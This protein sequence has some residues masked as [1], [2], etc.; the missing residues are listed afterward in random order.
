MVRDIPYRDTPRTFLFIHFNS[1]YFNF[2]LDKF[3]SLQKPFLCI[4]GDLCFFLR[5]Q[6][7]CWIVGLTVWKVCFWIFEIFF[8]NC[9]FF[10]RIATFRSG[11][12]RSSPGLWYRERERLGKNPWCSDKSRPEIRTKILRRTRRATG[13]GII[14]SEI[15]FEFW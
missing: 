8:W 7:S 11:P 9:L 15:W 4:W 13:W 2:V 5:F 12:V 3:I 1:K 6:V 10:E 14:R